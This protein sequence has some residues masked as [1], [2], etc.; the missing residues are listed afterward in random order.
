MIGQ[1]VIP[2]LVVGY[3]G[4]KTV[5]T[6]TCLSRKPSGEPR[7]G[8]SREIMEALADSASNAIR[9]GRTTRLV[10]DLATPTAVLAMV[11]SGWHPQDA[12]AQ[13]KSKIDS[14][15]LNEHEEWLLE[16]AP[17]DVQLA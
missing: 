6:L 11:W 15:A 17:R 9:Q 12:I 2:G 13:V 7:L 16:H 3:G 4:L 8:G 1:E 5:V 14:P 10:G